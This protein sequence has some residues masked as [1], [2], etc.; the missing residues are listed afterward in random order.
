MAISME[1]NVV[2]ELNVTVN[3]EKYPKDFP[4]VRILFINDVGT[5]S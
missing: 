2:N 4:H 3:K 5:L 1:M